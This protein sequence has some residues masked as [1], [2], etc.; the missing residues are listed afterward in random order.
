MGSQQKREAASATPVVANQCSPPLSAAPAHP[1]EAFIQHQENCH[2]NRLIRHKPRGRF[3][4]DDWVVE[5]AQ[6]QA[7]EEDW[8][9]GRKN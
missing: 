9:L 7:E 6:L 8:R 5:M 1:Q 3:K 2:Q 4:T